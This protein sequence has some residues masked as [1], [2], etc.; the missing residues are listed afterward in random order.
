MTNL[1]KRWWEDSYSLTFPIQT[2]GQSLRIIETSTGNCKKFNCEQHMIEIN[3]NHSNKTFSEAKN[4]ITQMFTEI[5]TKMDS[6]MKSNDKIRITFFHDELQEPIGYEFMSK[7]TLNRTSLQSKFESVIQSYKEVKLNSNNSLRAVIVIAHTPTGTGRPTSNCAY[8]YNNQQDFLS[9]RKYIIPVFNDD[10]F[11]AA[12]AVLIAIEY[13]RIKVKLNKKIKA[14]I[15]INKINKSNKLKRLIK[16]CKFA[17]KPFGLEEF[18]KME[19][20]LKDYQITIINEDGKRDNRKPIYIG[21]ANKFYIY[22]SYTGSHYNVINNIK[23]F[24]NTN[25]YCHDCKKPYKNRTDHV[26]YKSCYYCR[27][28]GCLIDLSS[29]NYCSFCNRKCNNEK[30]LQLHMYSTCIKVS[31]CKT[32]H[33]NLTKNHTCY[34]QKYCYNCKKIVDIDHK[35]YILTEDQKVFWI[36]IF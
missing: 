20:Y 18:K 28:I 13:Q 23:A 29:K 36:H 11:C 6:L 34:N 26:C 1:I 9:S 10:N 2:T 32:C 5:H 12:R 31:K 15:S 21:R 3:F 27:R 25:Y 14:E 17:D 8:F 22:L 16:K 30:C 19:V 33:F 24:Y 35:C 7:Q 4:D